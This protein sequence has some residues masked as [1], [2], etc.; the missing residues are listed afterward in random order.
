MASTVSRARASTPAVVRR[1]TSIMDVSAGT[2]S[3]IA[4]SEITSGILI[5]PHK[6]PRS[7]IM[8]KR[9]RGKAAARE[10]GAK[11]GLS[12]ALYRARGLRM[13]ASC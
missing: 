3:E 11:F 5:P 4:L 10:S 13:A 8:E 6:I 2:V 1:M 9:A 7:I 12:G